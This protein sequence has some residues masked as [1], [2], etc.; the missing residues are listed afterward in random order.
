MLNE[1]LYD[2]FHEDALDS[3]KWSEFN[4]GDL[5]SK[6]ENGTFIV[7]GWSTFPTGS[8]NRINSTRLFNNTVS[9]TLL[10]LDGIGHFSSMFGIYDKNTS[11][12]AG[13]AYNEILER[14]IIIIERKIPS[15]TGEYNFVDPINPRNVTITFTWNTSSVSI[16]IQDF[17]MAFNFSKDL[18]DN[19]CYC[20][21]STTAG[22]NDDSVIASWDN[23]LG[24]KIYSGKYL[25]EVCDTGYLEP[26]L[27]TTSWNVTQRPGTSISV[28]LRSSNNLDMSESN[29]WTIITNQMTSDFPSIMRYLQY[30][31]T[32]YN[33]DGIYS[34]ILHDISI[35]FCRCCTG[36]G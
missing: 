7:A 20:S 35:I 27:K 25:S 33:T 18:V 15:G 28:M 23:V 12:R 11:F 4:I 21:I 9:A 14:P 29:P 8:E 34:P 30:C 5:D 31:I 36:Q 19:D 32:F 6:L 1:V 13:F 2:D 10:N 17:L 22:S 3:E 16:K 24:E 26:L